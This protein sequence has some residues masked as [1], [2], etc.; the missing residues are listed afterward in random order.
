MKKM[1]TICDCKAIYKD[2]VN[3]VIKNQP[4]EEIIN[5]LS[6]FFKIISDPTRIKIIWNLNNEKMCVC[7]IANVLN[8]TKSAISHQLSLLKK[9]H[10][11]KSERNG[12]EVHYFLDNNMVPELYEI[13]LKDIYDKLKNK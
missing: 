11:V 5:K 2:I 3:K 4:R 12:K 9:Y 7:D 8:M 1:E 10:I 6:K 13:G